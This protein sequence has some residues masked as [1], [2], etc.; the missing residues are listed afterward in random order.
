MGDMAKRYN[1][2]KPRLAFNDLGRAI[3]EAEARVWE[4]GARKYDPGNWLEGRPV[5][6]AA[7]SLRRHL[8]A[9]LAGEDNDPE[10]GESHVGHIVCCAKILGQSFL[11]R[12]DLDDRPKAQKKIELELVPKGTY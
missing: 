12:P 8:D 2:G 3:N 1:S 9:F 7:D 11:T 10:T 4:M 6:D 5:M